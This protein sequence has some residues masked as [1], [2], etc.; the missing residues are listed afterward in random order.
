MAFTRRS[1]TKTAAL[2]ALAL[3]I[4]LKP[5][6]RHIV[7]GVLPAD[8]LDAVC[9]GDLPEVRRQLAADTS[10]LNRT[11]GAGRS[12][13][14]LALL[15]ARV[16][17]ADFLKR[18]GYESDMH[19]AALARDWERYDVLVENDRSM[20]NSD[21]PIGGTVMFAAASGGA[22]MDMWRIYAEAG[23]PNASPRGS[24]GVTPLQAA[25]MASDPTAVEM[26]VASLISND[27]HPDPPPN[28]A[29]P[30]LHL[31]AERGLSE[32]VEML[33]HFGADPGRRDRN[34]RTAA[35]Y[36]ERTGHTHVADLLAAAD[37]IP[38]LNNRYRAA[39]NARGEVYTEPGPSRLPQMEH[40]RMVGASHGDIDWVRTATR[41]NRNLAHS[42]ATTGER[43][44]E[45]GAHM[46]RRDIVSL[47]LELGAPC[48]LAT[49]VMLEET[50]MVTA[51]LDQH[52]DRIHERG[53]HGFP[54]LWYPIIGGTSLDMMQ[55][56][57]ERGCDVEQQHFLG[58]TALHWASRGNSTEMVALLLDH[59]ADPNRIGRK[60][61]GRPTT[62][63]QTAVNSN[64]NAIANLLRDRGAR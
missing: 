53:A 44:V 31:A 15:N 35:M 14:A 61:G 12:A 36:A 20:V 24:A 40:E 21:H 16:H 9:R 25:L 51:W 55:L 22:G 11:D 47:L 41:G 33:V 23:D 54:L 18:Q 17:V 8:F 59:G 50:E 19:E 39:F 2:G 29:A 56:L 7:N 49:A 48:S 37:E 62:P 34:G 4:P 57:I 60:F 58:T 46:G 43:A 42:I 45:A 6:E 26:T 30:P 52:P 63:L 1:F 32:L 27:T 5:R 3:S 64:R 28:A 38:R 13:Y 10:L